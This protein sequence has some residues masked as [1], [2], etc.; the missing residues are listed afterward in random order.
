MLIMASSI[1][2][3]KPIY[4]RVPL[5]WIIVLRMSAG[6]V[7]SYLVYLPVKNKVANLMAMYHSR[8]RV[9]ILLSF[10]TSSYLAVLCWLG[11]YKYL[12]ASL[13]SVLNQTSS[14]YTVL[15]AAVFL[16]EKLTK[17]KLLATALAVTGAA[18]ISLS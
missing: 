14:I 4:D 17:K 16:K 5:L 3:I 2:M 18:I 11:G 1:V 7:S 9:V 10:F 15:L 6:M 13:S 8:H 12:D